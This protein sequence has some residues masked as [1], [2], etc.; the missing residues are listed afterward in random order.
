MHETSNRDLSLHVWGNYPDRRLR[1]HSRV[2]VWGVG[3]ECRVANQYVKNLCRLV[4]YRALTR[5]DPRTDTAV[6]RVKT[7]EVMDMLPFLSEPMIRKRLKVRRLGHLQSCP[8]LL[9]VL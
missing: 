1:G 9:S 5:R 3:D 7:H 4:I 2:C 8:L 6:N